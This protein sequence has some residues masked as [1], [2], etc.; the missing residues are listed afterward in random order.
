MEK[1]V[2]S[3]EILLSVKPQYANLLITGVKTIELRKKFPTDLE[4]ETKIFIYS[5]FPEKKVIGECKISKIEYLRL[6]DLWRVASIEAMI[7]WEDFKSYYEGHTHG[8]AVH[9]FK[10][11]K[12]K[13]SI[14][15]ADID[16]RITQ[17]P[18]S[19]RYLPQQI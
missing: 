12:Y 1:K 15:L 4:K 2:T 17:A 11:K 13:E 16:P 5:S 3:R 6:E 10:A 9:V 18:Q 7:S 8:Y 14:F 19:Y